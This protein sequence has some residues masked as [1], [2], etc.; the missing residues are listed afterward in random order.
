MNADNITSCVTKGNVGSYIT[1]YYNNVIVAFNN[2][3][4]Y[5]QISAGEIAVY[6]NG[7]SASKNSARSTKTAIIFTEITTMWGKLV[8]INGQVTMHTK[9]LYLI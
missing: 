2:N 1:Q 9:D 7:V 6:D 3:S 8:Q 5:V 4:K